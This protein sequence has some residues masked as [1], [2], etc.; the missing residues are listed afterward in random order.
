MLLP[1]KHIVPV[2]A[3]DRAIHTNLYSGNGKTVI[4]KSNRINLFLLN[5]KGKDLNNKY[6]INH[7]KEKSINGKP[8]NQKGL[9]V[10]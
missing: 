3:F 1:I 6:R 9:P 10:G 2:V 4:K 5:C 7:Y 8:E